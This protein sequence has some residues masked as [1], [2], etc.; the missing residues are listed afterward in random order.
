MELARDVTE[1]ACKLSMIGNGRLWLENYESIQIYNDRE[2]LLQTKKHRIR[3]Q[4]DRLRIE[5]YGAVEMKV[6]GLIQSIVF[7]E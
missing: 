5:S 3:I 6:S 7:E 1:G 4:G 2:I